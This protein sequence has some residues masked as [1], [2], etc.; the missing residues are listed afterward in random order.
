MDHFSPFEEVE[1]STCTMQGLSAP[2]ARQI[3]RPSGEIATLDAPRVAI[4]VGM[5]IFDIL[6]SSSEDEGCCRWN[7]FTSECVDTTSNAPSWLM[8]AEA[9]LLSPFIKRRALCFRF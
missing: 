7:A 3:Q 8:A 5:V 1:Y 4:A 6:S 9:I 2:R